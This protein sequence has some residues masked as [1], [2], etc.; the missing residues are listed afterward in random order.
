MSPEPP[1]EAAGEAS[2]AWGSILDDF[3]RQLARVDLL[4]AELA[5]AGMAAP[6]AGLTTPAAVPPADPGPVPA[7]L[8]QRA[9]SVLAAQ[10]EAMARLETLRADLAR[11]LGIARSLGARPDVAVYLDRTA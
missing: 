2:S 5:E 9:D 11:H 3:E 6:P 4:A 1:P 8:R 7:E 10:R